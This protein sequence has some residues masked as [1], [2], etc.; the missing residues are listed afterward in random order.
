[1]AGCPVVSTR[2]TGSKFVRSTGRPLLPTAGLAAAV[3]EDCCPAVLVGLAVDPVVAV[4]AVVVAAAVVAAVV[5]VACGVLGA[6]AEGRAGGV[7]GAECGVSVVG[8]TVF[9]W[10]A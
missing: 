1:M 6:M 3:A 7:V 10:F 2:L 4:V 8:V 5:A 9:S